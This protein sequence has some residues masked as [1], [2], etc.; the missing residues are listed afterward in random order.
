MLYLLFTNIHLC[1]AYYHYYSS[2]HYTTQR[3]N[4]AMVLSLCLLLESGILFVTPTTTHV[5]HL[6]LV[7]AATGLLGAMADTGVQISLRSQWGE[8]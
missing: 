3:Y 4:A 8:E 1:P 6:H 2:Y 7:F 5:S